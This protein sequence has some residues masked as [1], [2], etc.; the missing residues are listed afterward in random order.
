MSNTIHIYFMWTDELTSI[1]VSKLAGFIT[2]GQK[3]IYFID[4]HM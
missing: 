1:F 4:L 2:I 3:I